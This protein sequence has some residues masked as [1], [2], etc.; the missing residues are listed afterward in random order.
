MIYF[1]QYSY[2]VDCVHSVAFQKRETNVQ[3]ILFHLF[4]FILFHYNY[5]KH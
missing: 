1:I 4:Y 2:S 5:Q 3:A